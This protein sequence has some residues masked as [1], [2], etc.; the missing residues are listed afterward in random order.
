MAKKLIKKRKAKDKIFKNPTSKSERIVV[1]EIIDGDDGKTTVRLLRAK[2]SMNSSPE[3]MSIEAWNSETEDFIEAWQVE[4]FVGLPPGRKLREGD[5]FFIADRS[6]LD[7]YYGTKRSKR[8]KKPLPRT[9]AENIH[10]LSP[11]ENSREV[12]RREIKMQFE[13][14]YATSITTDESDLNK[15]RSVINEKFKDRRAGKGGKGGG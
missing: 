11:E 14:L 7:K 10:L 6:K 1:D 13:N 3:D 5:V 15:M 9:V 12:A 4:A 2:R 8:H